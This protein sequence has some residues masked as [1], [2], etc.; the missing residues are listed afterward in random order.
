MAYYPGAGFA[1]PRIIR[2]RPWPPAGILPVGETGAAQMVCLKMRSFSER[3]GSAAERK[4]HISL[5]RTC[6]RSGFSLP[7]RGII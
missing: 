5:R 3:S 7:E 2:R 6:G 4:I 1:R